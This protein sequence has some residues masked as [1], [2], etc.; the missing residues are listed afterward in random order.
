MRIG[1]REIA[2]V[3]AIAAA[4]SCSHLDPEHRVADAAS[5]LPER[6]PDAAA[7]AAAEEPLDR[8]WATFES[9]ELDR[10][11][12]AAVAGNHDL[13]AAEAR[14]EPVLVVFRDQVRFLKHNLNARAVELVLERDSAVAFQGRGDAVARLGEHRLDRPEQLESIAIEDRVPLGHQ[15]VSHPGDV[16]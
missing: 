12:D 11:V 2:I 13:R 16:A 9:P 6:Y 10:L 1:L 15:G 8:Y 14:M 5:V 3:V 4:P 7:T